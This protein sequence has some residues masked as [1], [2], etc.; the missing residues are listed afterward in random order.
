[1]QQRTIKEIGISKTTGVTVS[2]VTFWKPVVACFRASY[3]VPKA[4]YSTKPG[5]QKIRFQTGKDLV[6][7][8]LKRKR[9]PE[10]LECQRPRGNAL[11]LLGQTPP[12][13]PRVVRGYRTDTGAEACHWS[14]IRKPYL[15][16]KTWC[17]A[18]GSNRPFPRGMAKQ[19]NR[20]DRHRE[21]RLRRR[22]RPRSDCNGK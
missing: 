20:S 19:P 21:S 14:G 9:N 13:S 8:G 5:D 7:C 18:Y 22:S 16:S 4:G 11:P 17:R 3:P 15:R 2:G 1:M 10:P 12:G 6:E